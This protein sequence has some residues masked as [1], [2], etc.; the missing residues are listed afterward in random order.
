MYKIILNEINNRCNVDLKIKDIYYYF[1]EIDFSLYDVP[2][3]FT[4]DYDNT[5]IFSNG[6]VRSGQSNLIDI[7][8]VTHLLFNLFPEKKI[9]LTHI[10][11]ISHPNIIYTSDIIKTQ[12]SDLNEISWVAEKCKYIIGRNSGPFCFMHTKNILNDKSK[13]IIAI[14][15]SLTESFVSGIDTKA[16]YIHLLDN[17]LN[18]LMKNIKK[19]WL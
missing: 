14:G 7:N 4:V 5:I 2:R 6:P 12:G 10:S 18:E 3:G 16:E 8:F 13:K 19:A 9:I 11:Q 1:P 15:N 17:D